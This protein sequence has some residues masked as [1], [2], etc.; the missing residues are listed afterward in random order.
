MLPFPAKIQRKRTEG[1]GVL[2]LTS[3]AERCFLGCSFLVYKLDVWLQSAQEKNFWNKFRELLWIQAA[4]QRRVFDNMQHGLSSPHIPSS[5]QDSY[6]FRKNGENGLSS[7]VPPAARGLPDLQSM[8]MEIRDLHQLKACPGARFYVGGERLNRCRQNPWTGL[9]FIRER[10]NLHLR[11]RF[12]CDWLIS[13]SSI[14][15]KFRRK[16]EVRAH[17]AAGLQAVS[18]LPSAIY[19]LD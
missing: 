16:K 8:W 12:R 6:R 13:K 2:F 3:T 14:K 15:N 17:G 11:R 9:A 5:A 1:F 19:K 4:I 10:K 7:P 18:P